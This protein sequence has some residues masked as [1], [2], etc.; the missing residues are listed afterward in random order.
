MDDQEVTPK[1][2]D[3]ILVRAEEAEAQPPPPLGG[4]PKQWVPWW[5]RQPLCLLALPWILFDLY[6]QK[7]ATLIIRPPQRKEGDCLRR[8]NCCHY[9][10][11][12]EPKGLLGRLNFFFNTQIYGFYPRFS[13]PYEY[14]GTKVVVMGCRYLEKD[15]SCGNYKLRPVVCRKWPMIEIFGTPRILKGCGFRAVPKETLKPKKSSLDILQ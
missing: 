10:L 15:G 9:I 13:E 14:D 12:P 11:I 1:T 2:L 4:I 3:E 8:G 7:L 6:L 5:I